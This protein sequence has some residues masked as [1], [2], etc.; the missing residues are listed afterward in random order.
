M[1]VK[2]MEVTV[3][4]DD[5]AIKK[6]VIL[7][8][9]LALVFIF[10]SLATLLARLRRPVKSSTLCSYPVYKQ[11]SAS[12]C[13]AR[14]MQLFTYEDLEEATKGFEEAQK[15]NE[16]ATG[17]VHYGVLGNGSHVA[18]QK[19]QCENEENLMMVLSRVEILSQVSHMSVAPL[20]GCCI[21]LGN[22]PQVVYEVYANGTLDEHLHQGRHK[23]TIDW[24]QRLNIAA[25]TASALAYLQYEISPPIYHHDLK[26]ACVFLDKDFSAKIA[27]FG[28]LNSGFEDG[29]HTRYNYEGSRFYRSDVYDF[30]VILLEIISGSKHV[31]LPAMALPKIRSGKLEEIVDPHLYYHEQPAFHREQIVIVADLAT[32]C[33]LFGGDGRLGMMD[34]AKE[35]IQIAKESLD[36]GRRGPALEETFQMISMSP[37]SIYL[38]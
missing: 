21:D 31:D 27:G 25:E 8:G 26:S 10:A 33:L 30:G 35:L 20:L 38:P 36:G 16:G 4:R 23:G 9:I 7:A 5:I 37:D 17:T 24:Q 19:F 34:A 29:I 18:V 13:K 1:D 6:V 2:H 3:T 32:R 28:L 14:Q 22:T 12:F 11:S 15:L